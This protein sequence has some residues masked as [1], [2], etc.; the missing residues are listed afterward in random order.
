MLTGLTIASSVWRVDPWLSAPSGPTTKPSR[1]RVA[2][3][4]L[5]RDNV[6]PH[7]LL[8]QLCEVLGEGPQPVP[9]HRVSV[10][11]T[12]IPRQT[13]CSLQCM[14][15]VLVRDRPMGLTRL[16]RR[17]A[18]RLRVDVQK[19]V[20]LT[21]DGLHDLGRIAERGVVF[22]S[23]Q[24]LQEVVA[25]ALSTLVENRGSMIPPPKQFST[26]CHPRR[27]RQRETLRV[28][29]SIEGIADFVDLDQ[30]TS[31]FAQQAVA[32]GMWVRRVVRRCVQH[33]RR[34]RPDMP[35]GDGESVDLALSGVAQPEIAPTDVILEPCS[36]ATD[37]A[38]EGVRRTTERDDV[39]D[40]PAS[41]TSCEQ[42]EREEVSEADAVDAGQ[43]KV[44]VE[45]RPDTVRNVP[46]ALRALPHLR[47]LRKEPK[48][49][50]K[51]EA[52]E[53]C[54]LA[55]RAECDKDQRERGTGER[56]MQVDKS[57]MQR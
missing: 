41:R 51:S 18:E 21:C 34:S 39:R 45:D 13:L 43:V 14:G 38:L 2:L 36:E 52:S 19:P 31:E 47:D 53:D 6:A 22:E 55:R 29:R 11:V 15:K 28:E 4:T 1:C 46:L 25:R 48:E 24:D 23:R 7:S 33:V 10:G 37:G 54:G 12:G 27:G 16:T 40:A 49:D 9:Q 44:R 26:R 30:R 50:R 5:L 3:L 20:L 32:R 17:L 42:A 56:R 35:E 57:V 8:V